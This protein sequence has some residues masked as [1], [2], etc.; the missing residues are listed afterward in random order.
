MV[1]DQWSPETF[2]QNHTESFRMTKRRKQKS[3]EG[4]HSTDKTT[5]ANYGP[6]LRIEPIYTSA[7]GVTW[8][9][10]LK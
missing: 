9:F 4:K 1:S 2:C 10:Y 6:E 8:F 5:V 3:F 7:F